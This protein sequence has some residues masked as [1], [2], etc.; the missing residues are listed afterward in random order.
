M[1]FTRFPLHPSLQ[2]AIATAG[3]DIPTPIQEAAIP[4]ALAGRDLLGTAQ[5]G[6][7]KTAAFALPILHQLLHE[8]PVRGRRMRALVLTPTRE[9]G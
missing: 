3:F 4:L 8:P 5:T 9:L 6:T 1:T 2:R 7:G